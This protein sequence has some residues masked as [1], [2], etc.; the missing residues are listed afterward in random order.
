MTVEELE[1]IVSAKI[2]QVKP[3]IQ[4]VVREIKSAVKDTEGLGA[5]IL[6]KSDTER[7]VSE[8]KKTSQQVKKIFN[9]SNTSDIERTESQ[10]Q[11]LTGK[12][13]ELYTQL[14]SLNEKL[15]ETPKGEEYDNLLR[16]MGQLNHELRLLDG[17][18]AQYEK[19]GGYIKYNSNGEQENKEIT[20]KVNVEEAKRQLT[21]LKAYLDKFQKYKINIGNTQLDFSKFVVDINRAKQ[22]TGE[23][24]KNLKQ[25]TAEKLKNGI[26]SIPSYLSKAGQGVKNLASKFSFVKSGASKLTGHLKVGLGQILRIAGSLIGLR[27]LY[28]GL[29]SATSSWLSSQNTQAKQLNTNIEYMKYAL[30]SSLQPVIETIVN[31]IYQALKG[32][33]SLIYA[34]TGVNI[35]ANASAKSYAS[36]AKNAK[37]AKDETL[38][39]ADI[40][41]IHNIQENKNNSGAGTPSSDLSGIETADW[42]QKLIDNIK[43]GNWYEIG[44]TIGTKINESL[45]KIP[46][47]KIKRTA[48]NAGKNVAQFFNGGI[49]T[50]DWKLVGGTIAEGVNTAINFA[51]SFVTTFNWKSFGKAIS[52]TINGFFE[53]I[54]WDKAGQT[55]SEGIKGVYDALIEYITNL[56]VGK[57]QDSVLD[58]LFNIDWA[59]VFGKLL[60]L[61]SKLVIKGIE[62]PINLAIKAAQRLSEKLPPSMRGAF[63]SLQEIHLEDSIL[64]LGA[65]NTELQNIQKQAKETAKGTEESIG[66]L[67]TVTVQTFDELENKTFSWGQNTASNYNSGISSQ[68]SN[69]NGIFNRIKTSLQNALNQ[70]NNSH[71]W[72]SSTASNYKNGINSQK[73]SIFDKIYAV[74]DRIKNSLN[75]GSSSKQWGSST[76]SRFKNGAD[77]QTNPLAK[78]FV[79]LRNVTETMKTSNSY[80]W[81]KDMVQG[82]I[83]GINSKQKPF[84]SIIKGM[85]DTVSQY[86]HFSRPD[87]GPLRY[88]ETWMPD[89]IKG[90]SDSLLQSAPMLDNAVSQ[91]SGNIADNLRATDLGVDV[92][93]NINKTINSNI[94]GSQLENAVYSAIQKAEN[95]FRLTINNE[96][97]LN[98]KTIAKEIID[99]LNDEARRR[100]YKPILQH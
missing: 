23:L 56:D 51:H 48:S 61:L 6:S 78:A 92:N 26:K 39:V 74:K 73:T 15:S 8:A 99:D 85:A 29:R 72:G 93:S 24:A 68:Q 100:G 28:S 16:K 84:T 94:L 90:L 34:L 38:K 4:K 86:I 22:K 10:F 75:L 82:F 79:K 25:A 32:V 91:V 58:F 64:S 19:T 30:G 40:D 18:S 67:N 69:S 3:Q 50:T 43:N 1:I 81:G 66:E 63:A 14:E 42:L 41:E 76:I 52:N 71:K 60:E 20:P 49:E 36:M 95:L 7:I 98:T 77:G 89:M 88:Y 46:W 21:S 53:K 44:A 35:F 45:E 70:S 31:L 37:K 9:Q 83:N 55:I 5:K 96:L 65:Y 87:K 13:K 97:K 54:E 12:G 62:T 17:T 2:E 80:T 59:G 27:A 11:K 57:I 33:Q 47:D